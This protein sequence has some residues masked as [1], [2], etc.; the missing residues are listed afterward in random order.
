MLPQVKERLAHG[1]GDP[2]NR[3]VCQEQMRAQSHE[4]VEQ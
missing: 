4:P 1:L 3:A 2:L